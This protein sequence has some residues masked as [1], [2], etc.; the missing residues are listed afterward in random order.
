MPWL[1]AAVAGLEPTSPIGT[2]PDAMA[3]MTSPPPPNIFQLI[4]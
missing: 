1:A 4:L 2:S 3:L